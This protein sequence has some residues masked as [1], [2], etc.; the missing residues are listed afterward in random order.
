MLI[1]LNIS[2]ILNLC[3]CTSRPELIDLERYRPTD[4]IYFVALYITYIIPIKQSFI[5][6]N[7]IIIYVIC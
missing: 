1:G 2:Y 4:T 6:S 3:N 5:S 7:Y